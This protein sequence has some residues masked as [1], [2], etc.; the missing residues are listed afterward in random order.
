MKKIRH[1]SAGFTL[2]E[3]MISMSIGMAL[4]I[5]AAGVL[6]ET[7]KGYERLN[8]D[9]LA[10]REARVAL[11]QLKIDLQSATFQ[12]DMRYER[13]ASDWAQ[14][15]IGFF[16]FQSPDAQSETG[17]IGDLCAIHYYV[18]NLTFGGRSVRCLMRGF[19][20]SDETFQALKNGKVVDLFVP[21]DRDE[22]VAFGALAFEA[23]PETRDDK[24]KWQDWSPATGSPPDR[25]ILRLTIARR[26]LS[27]K[28]AAPQDWDQTG[29]LLGNPADAA[30]HP[31]LE[32][33]ET[34][35]RFGHY[36]KF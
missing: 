23:V 36:E 11:D 16:A 9:L 5:L 21:R 17:H 3:M 1:I 10:E 14:D 33:Y 34:A 32:F 30:D 4:L 29:G 8:G 35:M 28:L 18:R 6:G 26:D 7:G 2:L 27:S 31:Q 20:E 15:R 12:A 22:P 24:G 13:S 19:R 25:I